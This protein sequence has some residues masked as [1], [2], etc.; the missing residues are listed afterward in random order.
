VLPIW[1]GIREADVT[2]GA[3]PKSNAE[4]ALNIPDA[5]VGGKLTLFIEANA[6]FDYNDYYA[7]DLSEGDQGY[8]D[9]NGQPSALWSVEINTSAESGSLS[10]DLLGTGEVLGADHELHT[11]E[12][13]T[14]AASLLSNIQVA[15][16]MGE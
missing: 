16:K 13:L 2:S 5:F 8:S 15:W 3:T 1:K 6:S 14:S 11:S 4:L 7:E 9:V 10:P 12:H